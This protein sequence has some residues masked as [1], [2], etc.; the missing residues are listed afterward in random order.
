LPN[1]RALGATV[2]SPATEDNGAVVRIRVADLCGADAS[3]C[4]T[5]LERYLRDTEAEKLAHGLPGASTDRLP[6]R[7][8]AEIRDPGSAL[9]GATMLLAFDDELPVG[10]AVVSGDEIKRLFVSELARGQGV[11]R[12][13]LEA[14]VALIPGETRLTVWSWRTAALQLYQ[15]AGFVQVESWDG[16]GGLVCLTRRG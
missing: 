4:A 7:Y 1:R 11:G 6:A 16:R 13:L 14:A 3:D 10:I 5:L 9:A 8:R 12:Q 2:W 15:R